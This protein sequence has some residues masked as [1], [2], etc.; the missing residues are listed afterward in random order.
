MQTCS[1]QTYLKQNHEKASRSASIPTPFRFFS[2]S[3]PS[4]SQSQ[5]KFREYIL[6]KKDTSSD[7]SACENNQLV[8]IKIFALKALDFYVSRMK[9]FIKTRIELPIRGETTQ[10][11]VSQSRPAPESPQLKEN[12]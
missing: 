2:F 1:A 9:R 8:L 6:P 5:Q 7:I 10:R 12:I 3:C 4:T 11:T